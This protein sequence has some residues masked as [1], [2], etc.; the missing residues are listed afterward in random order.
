MCREGCKGAG[1]KIDSSVSVDKVFLIEMRWSGGRM[2][3]R[4]VAKAQ[5]ERHGFRIS[6]L[7]VIQEHCCCTARPVPFERPA[8][9]SNQRC[10]SL[11]WRGFGG[12]AAVSGQTR[13]HR[14]SSP[15]VPFAF[16]STQIQ[17]TTF[18]RQRSARG[19][20]TQVAVKAECASGLLLRSRH[21]PEA[22]II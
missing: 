2:Q 17:N 18:A 7:P 4:G 20:T 21:E 5:R 22:S 19:D 16:A 10:K 1:F 12:V 9:Q 6:A 13:I 8:S 11:R 15:A 3:R 14:E